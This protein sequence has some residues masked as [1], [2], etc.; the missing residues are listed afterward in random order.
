MAGA[1]AAGAARQ[2]AQEF[3]VAFA[4]VFE[5]IEG[6]FGIGAAV[7]IVVHARVVGGELGE[8]FGEE[9][10][11]PGAVAVGFGVREVRQDFG[12]GETVRGGLPAGVFVT[13]S[14]Q[15]AAQDGGSGFELVEAIELGLEMGHVDR[16]TG[17]S[18]AERG[19]DR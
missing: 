3:D 1:A 2:G 9:A 17:V 11:E 19:R 12:D 5:V 13:E 14:A 18:A 10:I 4:L 8:I 7:E 6:N 15:E 16:L